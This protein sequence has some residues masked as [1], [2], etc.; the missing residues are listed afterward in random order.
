MMGSWVVDSVVGSIQSVFGGLKP[1]TDVQHNQVQDQPKANEEMSMY[2][3]EMQS[4]L[5]RDANWDSFGLHKEGAAKESEVE[6]EVIE[7]AVVA[8]KA[9]HG[10]GWEIVALTS[11]QSAEAE[12]AVRTLRENG[13]VDMKRGPVLE[14]NLLFVSHWRQMALV[15]TRLQGVSAAVSPRWS[16]LASMSLAVTGGLHCVLSNPS[17]DERALLHEA[18]SLQAK[19]ELVLRG[20]LSNLADVYADMEDIRRKAADAG[21]T[22]AQLESPPGAIEPQRGTSAAVE[23]VQVALAASYHSLVQK[24][25]DLLRQAQPLVR[26]GPSLLSVVPRCAADAN[27]NLDGWKGAWG[28][29]CET[30]GVDK[31][32]MLLYDN[33]KAVTSRLVASGMMQPPDPRPFFPL[34]DE[35]T[36]I[37]SDKL[38][39]LNS[40]IVRTR[41]KI[42]VGVVLESGGHASEGREEWCVASIDPGGHAARSNKVRVG[43]RVVAVNGRVLLSSMTSTYVN[44]L[45]QGPPGTAVL[46]SMMHGALSRELVLLLR[47]DSQ[48]LPSG[49]KGRVVV[50]LSTVLRRKQPD[51]LTGLGSDLVITV[52]RG[53][54]LMERLDSEPVFC[55]VTVSGPPPYFTPK[56]MLTGQSVSTHGT[57]DWGWVARIPVSEPARQRFTIELLRPNVSAGSCEGRASVTVANL[58]ADQQQWVQL[59]SENG[60]ALPVRNGA[61]APA[62][63]VQAHLHSAPTIPSQPRAPLK[64]AQRPASAVVELYEDMHEMEARFGGRR[65]L[66]KEIGLDIAAALKVNPERVK[67]ASLRAGSVLARVNFFPSTIDTRTPVGLVSDLRGMLEDK[68]S[69]LHV[70]QTTQHAAA[71]TKVAYDEAEESDDDDDGSEE[72]MSSDD[73]AS[74]GHEQLQS[75]EAGHEDHTKQDARAFRPITSRRTLDD[76]SESERTVASLNALAD[77]S[78]KSRNPTLEKFPAVISIMLGPDVSLRQ[79]TAAQKAG[80]RLLLRQAIA[81]ALFISGNLVHIGGEQGSEQAAGSHAIDVLIANPPEG[82]KDHS[83]LKQ[84]DMLRPGVQHQKSAQFVS[85]VFDPKEPLRALNNSTLNRITWAQVIQEPVMQESVRVF[86]VLG[87]IVKEKTALQAKKEKMAKKKEEAVHAAARIWVADP[88]LGRVWEETHDEDGKIWLDHARK[89]LSRTHPSFLLPLPDGW[90]EK[91]GLQRH[92]Y[93]VNSEGNAQWEHPLAQK[94]DAVRDTRDEL[95]VQV[96]VDDV[97]ML[98]IEIEEVLSAGEENSSIVVKSVA[99]G[100]AGDKSGLVQGDLITRIDGESVSGPASDVSSKIV[101][102]PG[103]TVRMTLLRAPAFIA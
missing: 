32:R 38:A 62:L 29:M 48:P 64:A 71:V 93:Y 14:H 77:G 89:V 37:H 45:L 18:Q 54:N 96:A 98:G 35:S 47:S 81:D 94:M 76:L 73:R 40:S 60:D 22:T 46:L 78:V 51:D 87:G 36:K 80:N 83:L 4:A 99:P 6:L 86:D 20:L 100:G 13:I 69:A 3:K 57:V 56:Q 16:A 30:L 63:L 23:K 11:A 92:I 74:W 42:G 70:A 21:M 7:G 59:V 25:N 53:Q 39:K 8:L 31:E 2:R 12:A 33:R 79:R 55:R 85:Q 101:G 50:D 17:A 27:A 88:V 58:V 67:V 1:E 44:G 10:A 34:R 82:T 28:E 61:G 72:Q 95:E 15:V 90:E 84:H 97:G 91:I 66:K 24:E 41:P 52:K 5:A 65:K 75:E 19:D 103:E 49:S 26:L 68:K 9:L 43:D 102:V